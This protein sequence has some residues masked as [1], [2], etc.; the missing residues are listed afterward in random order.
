MATQPPPEAQV[1]LRQKIWDHTLGGLIEGLREAKELEVAGR[2]KDAAVKRASVWYSYRIVPGFLSLAVGEVQ[3]TIRIIGGNI[4]RLS[5]GQCDVIGTVMIAHRNFFVAENFLLA[6]LMK[7]PVPHSEALLRIGMAEVC[8]YSGRSDEEVLDYLNGALRL[9]RDVENEQDN[10]Q[11]LRQFCRVLLRAALL[12]RR[13][14]MI[15]LAEDLYTRA[16]MIATDPV[17]GS[18]GQKFKVRLGWKFG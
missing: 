14:G 16:L 3:R 1:S 10:V 4:D 8:C 2:H 12:H 9:R 18:A 5:D 13:R 17:T 7:N 11:A 6:G 15:G